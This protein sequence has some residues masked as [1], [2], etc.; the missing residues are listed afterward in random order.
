MKLSQLQEVRYAGDEYQD[1]KRDMEQGNVKHLGVSYS[2]Q[3]GLGPGDV[4]R[5]IV[6][7]YHGEEDG[8]GAGLGYR[9]HDFRIPASAAETIVG[10]IETFLKSEGLHQS[11][12]EIGLHDIEDDDE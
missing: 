5:D 1:L 7:E 10:E 2:L 8:S 3:Y 9:D 6:S 4:I 12:Y 11:E